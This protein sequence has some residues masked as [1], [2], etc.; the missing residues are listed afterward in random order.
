[1][2]NLEDLIL[3]PEMEQFLD[4]FDNAIEPSLITYYGVEATPFGIKVADIFDC[5]E[6]VNVTH[7]AGKG[8]FCVSAVYQHRYGTLKTVPPTLSD[9]M[10]PEVKLRIIYKYLRDTVESVNVFKFTKDTMSLIDSFASGQDGF[11]DREYRT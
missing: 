6:Y 9:D 8:P 3:F 1:M 4:L 11:R 7:S 5:C 2:M 10:T